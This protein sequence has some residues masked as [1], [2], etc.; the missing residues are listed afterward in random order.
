MWLYWNLIQV[1][2]D[3]EDKKSNFRCMVRMDIKH[4]RY[5]RTD[6]P[7]DDFNRSTK[8]PDGRQHKCRA[9]EST[10]NQNRKEYR[11]E[12]SK[13]YRQENKEMLKAAPKLWRAKNREKTKLSMREWRAANPKRNKENQ[14]RSNNSLRRKTYRK[15]WEIRNRDKIRTQKREYVRHKRA[16]DP[17]FNIRSRLTIR[18]RGLV[19]HGKADSTLGLLGCTLPEFKAYFEG[20]FT[21][22]MNWDA[23]N[24]GKIHIDHQRPCCSFDLTD[25]GQ[26]RECFC[27]TNLQPLWQKDNLA[28][29]AEDLKLKRIIS[30][31]STVNT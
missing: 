18:L 27:Y 8:A 20:L 23:F 5:C 4:C 13:R 2:S 22:E 9:C 1:S 7:L 31:V 6:K 10:Y 3:L 14:R 12:W 15:K 21:P 28:K 24:K 25:P 29:I 16:T 17:Q 19:K 11:R 30:R 26:Q